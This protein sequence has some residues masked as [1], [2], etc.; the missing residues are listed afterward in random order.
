MWIRIEILAAAA[1][2][3]VLL[4][5]TAISSI[6]SAARRKR[7][8]AREIAARIQCDRDEWAAFP[9]V[10]SLLDTYVDIVALT[11][12]GSS[13]AKKFR[14]NVV[15]DPLLGEEGKAALHIFNRTADMID[16]TWRTVHGQQGKQKQ[17]LEEFP[18]A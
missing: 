17:Q 5:G 15:V 14:F 2:L 12:P 10:Q 8:F 9:R 16:E 11:G 6:I 1:I 13:T 4:V 18:K 7:T 3:L